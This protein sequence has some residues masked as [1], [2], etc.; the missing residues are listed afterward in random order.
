MNV[1]RGCAVPKK[2]REKN[3]GMTPTQKKEKE[4]ERDYT[5]EKGAKSQS[6][7]PSHPNSLSYD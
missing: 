5:R 2:K 3:R 1:G 6:F 7:F 4:G